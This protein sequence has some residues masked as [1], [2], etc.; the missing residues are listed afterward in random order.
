MRAT[1]EVFLKQIERYTDLGPT[2]ADIQR[3]TE[4][5]NTLDAAGKLQKNDIG[6]IVFTFG[7]HRGKR[8]VDCLDYARWMLAAD[9]SAETKDIL[10]K[11]IAEAEP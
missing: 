3:M 9:F 11:V 8:V 10:R 2:V 5:L 4:P 7:K 6:E 1:L